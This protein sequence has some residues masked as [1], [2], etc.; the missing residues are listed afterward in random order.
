MKKMKVQVNFEME[1]DLK[2]LVEK[3]AEQGD[4]TVKQFINN[5]VMNYIPFYER[6]LKKNKEL[7]NKYLTTDEQIQIYYENQKNMVK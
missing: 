7:I 1:D 6:G 4:I 2:K 3:L 5:A